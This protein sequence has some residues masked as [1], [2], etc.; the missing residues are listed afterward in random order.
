MRARTEATFAGNFCAGRLADRRLAEQATVR[1]EAAPEPTTTV[2]AIRARSVKRR[3]APSYLV[4]YGLRGRRPVADESPGAQVE[5]GHLFAAGLAGVDELEVLAATVRERDRRLR[6]PALPPLG[7][8]QQ[9]G[10][11][12]V[13]RLR[14]VVLE[15]DRAIVV[16]APLDHPSGLQ[17]PEAARED[18]PRR[19]G[20]LRDRVEA[21]DVVGQLPDHEQRPLLAEDVQSGG[22]GAGTRGRFGHGRSVPETVDFSNSIG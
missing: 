1:A 2:A 16:L 20:V 22:D 19:T 3:T 11:Q 18:V 21:V 6:G 8:A 7:E 12:L 17:A 4:R 14:E 13:P 9:H 15:A 5:P 10:P